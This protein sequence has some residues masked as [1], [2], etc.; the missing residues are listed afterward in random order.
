M[1]IADTAR[2]LG[3]VATPQSYDWQRGRPMLEASADGGRE[4]DSGN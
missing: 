1:V 3:K 2:K 4:V